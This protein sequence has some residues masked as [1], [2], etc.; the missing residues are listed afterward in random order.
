MYTDSTVPLQ[1]PHGHASAH[2]V[3]FYESDSFLHDTVAGFLAD[4]LTAG[5]PAIV[6]A[7]DAH[8]KGFAAGLSSR[9]VDA[10]RAMA[11]GQ[12]TL[13]RAEEVLARIM[14]GG[15]PDR[16][17]FR[18][19][20]GARF[21]ASSRDNDR[22][23]RAFGEMVDLL[24]R[25][26][27]PEAAVRLEELWNELAQVRRFH[28]LCAYP[29]GNF[30]GE[31]HVKRFDE[32]CRLHGE[33]LP[34]ERY[35][36]KTRDAR[37]L[38]EIAQLQQRARALESEVRRR[39]RLERALRDSLERETAARE[40]AERASRLKD[41]FLAVLSHEL[42]TPLNAILGWRQIV[43]DRQ[44]DKITK[45]ALEVIG[46]NATLQMHLIDDLL[47][48]SRI[49]T[50]KMIIA[51]DPVDVADVVR[52]AADTVRPAAT[53]KGIA[54]DL[55]IDNSARLV[56]G[57]GARLQQVFWNLLSNAIKF[58]PKQGRVAVRLE[59]S[60]SEVLVT[61]H[62]DGEGIAPEF[63]PH[64]F[65]RFRQAD[66]STTRVYG[67]LGLG[68]AVV[69][70]LVEAHGGTVAAASD[71]I[72]MGATFTVRLP[73][74]AAPASVVV[75]GGVPASATILAGVQTL[76][77]D[78]NADA[79]ELMRYVLEQLGA[80]VETAAS[81]DEAL[82]LTAARPF[83]VVV[84]DIGMPDRDG[85][86]LITEIRAMQRNTRATVRAVAATAYAGEDSRERAL[87]A[88][89]DDYLLK[90]IDPGQLAAAILNLLGRDAADEPAANGKKAS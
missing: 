3:Q 21:D 9:G 12:L 54:L 89:F 48:V 66:N 37:G 53:A 13:L 75:G 8:N 83:D 85:Y 60:A 58:T 28:L 19:H 1:L 46:R 87:A 2:T 10:E 26:G 56:T 29:I 49:I 81:T 24:W 32:V 68:L 39:E 63:V 72:G 73:L 88:G 33:V 80:E 42:R 77:V 20:V 70:Y 31:S 57:D 4:G 40:E 67:G 45:R 52:A 78:D 64:V 38:L 79:R 59:R 84:A 51:S 44:A 82:Q 43:S 76:V 65:D 62:D 86:E 36:G 15:M 14:D 18:T 5:Q 7:T 23:M 11:S 74:R 71:G 50:G 22:C 47:D 41:E 30:A 35:R 61:V 6:I 55:S 17:L 27:N 16:D 34:T 69:R 90:P 25:D